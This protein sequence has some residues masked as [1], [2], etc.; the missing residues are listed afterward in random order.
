MSAAFYG[1]SRTRKKRNWLQVTIK[2]KPKYHDNLALVVTGDSVKTADHF[3]TLN[4]SLRFYRLNQNLIFSAR[5]SGITLAYRGC[6]ASFTVREQ[7]VGKRLSAFGLTV[8]NTRPATEY[9]TSGASGISGTSPCTRLRKR[10]D[11]RAHQ[12]GGQRNHRKYYSSQV[13][14]R[15][16]PSRLPERS[17]SQSISPRPSS[18][19]KPPRRHWSQRPNSRPSGRLVLEPTTHLRTHLHLEPEGVGA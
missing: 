12:E 9:E 17:S 18:L 15:G 14:G 13:G 7:P 5:F 1:K 3:L 10:L 11:R 8:L 4:L 2:F 16:N 6:K 19:R